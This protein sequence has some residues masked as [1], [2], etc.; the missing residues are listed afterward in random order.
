MIS[1]PGGIR[2][3][4]IGAFAGHA[5][6]RFPQLSPAA[7]C[8][9]AVRDMPYALDGAHDATGLLEQGRGDCLAKSE[10]LS[11]ALR[12]L[13]ARTRFVRWPYLLPEVVPEVAA[14]P[15]RLD[16]HRAVHVQVGASWVLA[17]AT[18]HPGLR[19]TALAVNDWDGSHDTGPGYPPAGP[20]IIGEYP[21]DR[22]ASTCEEATSWTANCPAEILTR[23]RSA[24]IA[25]LRQHE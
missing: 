25:W 21:R 3:C 9:Y 10:L 11:L 17:D 8:F 22:V 4:V 14:L 23:W 15:A 2:P 6:A 5:R 16:V 18:H 13:G 24:Y 12:Q 1:S 19:G 7:A 20:M